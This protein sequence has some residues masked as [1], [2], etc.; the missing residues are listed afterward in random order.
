M[1]LLNL[2]GC[3]EKTSNL[4]FLECYKVDVY[5]YLGN[6]SIPTFATP[7]SDQGLRADEIIECAL[8]HSLL[9]HP[10]V[11]PRRSMGRQ[12]GR[13]VIDECIRCDLCQQW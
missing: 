13:V 10:R 7:G 5:H 8:L 1:S 9:N 3:Q 11:I 12:L 4:W 2:H 6:N